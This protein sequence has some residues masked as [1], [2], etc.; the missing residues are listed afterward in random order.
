M[1][2][3]LQVILLRCKQ[4]YKFGHYFL[5]LKANDA[6]MRNQNE[7]IFADTIFDKGAIKMQ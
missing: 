1:L 2:Y 3:E 6:K 7:L 4:N 5:L